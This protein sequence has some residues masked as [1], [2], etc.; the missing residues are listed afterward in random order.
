MPVNGAH[1]E[2]VVVLRHTRHSIARDASHATSIG[3]HRRHGLA[4]HYLITSDIRFSIR[5]PLQV[6]IVGESRGDDADIPRASWRTRQRSEAGR[7]DARDICSVSKV[8]E[9]W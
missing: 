5:I 1:T 8:N 6:R 9:L 7:I 4:P 3:P 2:K